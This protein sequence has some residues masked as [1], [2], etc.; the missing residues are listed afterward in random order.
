MDEVVGKLRADAQFDPSSLAL[1]IDELS[2]F[3]RAAEPYLPPD[4]L[5]PA[6]EV[7]ARAGARLARSRAH[8]VVAVAGGTGSGKSSLFNA[9]A[10]MELSPVGLRR[11][12]TGA[13]YACV[14]GTP[15]EATLML[16]WLR[17]P[18]GNRFTRESPDG[19][20]PSL[21]GLVLLDLPDFDSVEWEHAAEVDRLLELVDLVVWVVDPQK[22]A[23]RV[24]HQRYLRRFHRHREVTLVALNQADLLAAGDLPRLL[25]DLDQLLILDGLAGAPTLAT[26]AVVG[27]SGLADLRAA[28]VR[29]VAARRAALHR[30]AADVDQV[31]A[32]LADLVGPEPP[33]LTMDRVPELVG[34]LAE[35]AGVPALTRAVEAGYRLRAGAAMSGP[36]LQWLRRAR[37]EP[38]A[39]PV[40]DPIGRAA[41]SLAVRTVAARASTRLPPPWPDAVA[42]ASRSHLADLPGGLASALAAARAEPGQFGSP[43]WWR[44][45]GAAQWLV[46]GVVAVGV[47]WL[48]TGWVLGLVAVPVTHPRVGAA[49]VPVLLVAGGLTAGLALAVLAHLLARW[50][51]RQERIRTAGRFRGAVA[52]VARQ[53]V[54]EPVREVLR[55]YREARSALHAAGA[56]RP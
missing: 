35:A 48:L 14:W 3:R 47:G 46:T 1:R 25:A 38:L 4:W 33:E 49:P 12:T 52:E 11:P 19:V 10:G 23:D 44:L 16:D 37:P 32:G 31:V 43:G 24:L 18:P 45:V 40:P 50:A 30:L 27:Q 13:P 54:V 2:R 28:L 51:A 6:R 9:L 8:T 20:Q 41:T 5:E 15:A 7:A 29:A 21:R 39:A 22:Y 34:G 55:A 26:S 42:D 36:V 53:L 56:G 17:V